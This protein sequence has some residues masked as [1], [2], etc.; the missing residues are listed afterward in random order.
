[1]EYQD[2]NDIQ[3]TFI[4]LIENNNVY[5]VGDVKQSIYRFRNANPYIFKNKYDAYSN[6]QNGIK[7]DLVQNFRSRSEVLDNINTV[8]KLIM[9][10]EIGGAAY[11][12][13]HQMIYGNKSYISE[14]KTDYN[15]NF[16]ILEY[17]LPDDKTYSKAEIEIFTIAKDIKNK[18]SSKYQIFD[19]DE[20]VLRD[21]SYKDF[22]ILLDR[23]ADF[24]LYKKI[25]EY[26]GIPL[27]VFKELNLNNSN[28][29]YILKNIID[30]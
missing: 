11:E 29:I 16:E 20:K 5:M 17:N 28:D 8:F 23:S 21:I 25:F 26:E 7:I 2:T 4:S 6:N 3:E 12:Q 30:Y 22:V 13:S 19:K 10:D 15:Y 14:G 9:D 18:V 1:D 27:T 24:D